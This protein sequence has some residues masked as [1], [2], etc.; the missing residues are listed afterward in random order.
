MVHR[1]KHIL[2]TLISLTQ[3]NFVLGWQ[4]SDIV[5]IMQ[6]VYHMKA[7]RRK[8]GITVSKIDL[9]KAYH[10]LKWSF[11]HETLIDMGI[12]DCMVKVIKNCATSCIMSVLWNG[13]PKR[14]P[15]LHEGL[16]KVIPSSHICLEHAW[17]DY[18]L[19]SRMPSPFDSGLRLRLDEVGQHLLALFLSKI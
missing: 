8:K 1:L 9:E 3:A 19:L 6:E 17:R 2:P 11:I 4:I 12:L 18:H 14:N 10:K 16:D 13:E 7:K 5:V 15:S